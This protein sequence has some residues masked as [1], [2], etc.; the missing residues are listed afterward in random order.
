MTYKILPNGNLRIEAD[1][2]EMQAA[3][4]DLGDDFGSDRAMYDAFESLI[5]SSDLDWIRPEEI[6]ALTDAPI[7]GIRGEDKPLPEGHAYGYVTG[8]S[9]GV[10]YYAPVLKAWA[11]MDYA[12]RSPQDDLAEQGYCVFQ[13]GDV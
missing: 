9:E 11:F 3:K 10:T 2:V 4:A 12:L 6:G 13:G 8:R 1:Q 5:G 7:L